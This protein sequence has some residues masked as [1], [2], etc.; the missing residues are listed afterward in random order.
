MSPEDLRRPSSP[1]TAT[2][3]QLQRWLTNPVRERTIFHVDLLVWARNQFVWITLR[4][5]TNFKALESNQ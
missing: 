5:H 3:L 2:T 4:A 1:V